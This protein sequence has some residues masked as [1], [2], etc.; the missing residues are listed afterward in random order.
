MEYRIEQMLATDES[1]EEVK[2]LLHISFPKRADKFSSEYLKWQ[3]VD[4]PRGEVIAYNAYDQD[5][6]IAAHYA[7]I[8]VEMM[9]E[10][11]IVKGLLSLNT[12]THPDHRG[13]RLFTI[14]A[15]RTYSRAQELGHKFVIGVANANSTHGFLKNLGFYLIA[16]LEVKVGL[17]SPFKKKSLLVEKNHIHYDEDT[18]RW[19]LR[20]PY[21]SY[22]YNGDT[23]YSKIDKPLF[24]T[25]VASVIEPI[26]VNEL[27]LKKTSAPLNLYVGLGYKVGCSYFKLPSFIKRSPFNLIFKDLS[28]G[29]LPKM[30]TGNITFQLLD[31]DVA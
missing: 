16:P 18:M 1:I 26:R 21:F 31:F 28:E 30:T 24:H 25:A 17:G 27:G 7:V 14:L 3:Y 9:I 29:Q 15:E 5:G 20:C 22:S 6:N 13:K 12:A 4:N 11:K 19:R 23:I 2:K 8:P 10:G